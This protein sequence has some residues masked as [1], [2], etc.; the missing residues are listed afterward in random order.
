M[1]LRQSLVHLRARRAGV[2]NRQFA[3]SLEVPVAVEKGLQGLEELAN[4]PEPGGPVHG[5]RPDADRLELGRYVAVRGSDGR[6]RLDAVQRRRERALEGRQRVERLEAEQLEQHGAERVDVGPGVDRLATGLLGS[7][8]A[9]RPHRFTCDRPR[10]RVAA[11]RDRRPLAGRRI[12]GAHEPG[13]AP[14]QH[15]HLAETAKHDV[16]W[17]EIAVHNA[18][19]VRELDRLTDA[20]KGRQQL[21]P[22][23]L[24]TRL[25]VSGAQALDDPFERLA[26]HALH[27]E[28][29]D[30]VGV[31]AEV[32][33]RNDGRMLQLALDAGL[34]EEAGHEVAP[35][36][37]VGS[38]GLEGHLASDALVARAPHDPHAAFPQ[39]GA[40]LVSDRERRMV[41]ECR[42]RVGRARGRDGV[43][44]RTVDERHGHVEIG[45]AGERCDA[46][47]RNRGIL[48]HA[49]ILVG[50]RKLSGHVSLACVWRA[51]VSAKCSANKSRVL[52]STIDSRWRR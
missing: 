24:T 26:V 48:A 14:V 18:T 17:F 46:G 19:R 16:G 49:R 43:R 21:A 33:D 32:V 29:E 38:H 36:A 27:R 47:T 31:A 7:H 42:H 30:A 35:R 34:P 40:G 5:R 15:V 4:A 20:R 50:R 11:G 22:R 45:E 9:G 44:V 51:M 12:G 25:L 41:E 28:V 23:V 3:P 37:V 39:R 6:T 13:D 2:L 52:S 1:S 10:S 8:V